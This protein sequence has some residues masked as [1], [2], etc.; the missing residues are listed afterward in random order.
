MA[1]N[2]TPFEVPRPAHRIG[3]LKRMRASVRGW[4]SSLLGTCNWGRCDF[5]ALTTKVRWCCSRKR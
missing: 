4:Q 5:L 1:Q 3:P 2:S